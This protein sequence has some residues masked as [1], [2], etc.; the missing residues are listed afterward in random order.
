MFILGNLL[1]AVAKVLSIALEVY[2]WVII[3]RALISWVRPDPYSPVV[4]ALHALTEPVLR[5]IRRLVGFG[6]GI[7]IS[8]MIAILVI[9][10]IKYFLIASLLDLA[11][12]LKGQ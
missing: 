1:Y 4:R 2:M 6:V 10:F 11:V 3:I 7:D 9:L 12:R 8:P 5:P